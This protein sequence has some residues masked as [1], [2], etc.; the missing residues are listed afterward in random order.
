MT[1]DHILLL[2]RGFKNK[3]VCI[4]IYIYIYDCVC[5]L[6]ACIWLCVCVYYVHVY[7][8]VCVYIMCMYTTLFAPSSITALIIPIMVTLCHKPCPPPSN[9]SATA[10]EKK[11]QKFLPGKVDHAQPC[12]T[13]W[14]F[15]SKADGPVWKEEG[16]TGSWR[17]DSKG[18][19][20]LQNKKD[21]N[22]SEFC[23]R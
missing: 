2:G 7:D 3:C 14:F 17:L 22:N 12:P 4:Y 20:I 16:F 5:I 1:L 6:C 13:L 9:L 21:N 19:H 11:D 18:V 10:W 15:K 8:C 23:S